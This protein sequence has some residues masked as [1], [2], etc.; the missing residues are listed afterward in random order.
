MDSSSS[1]KDGGVEKSTSGAVQQGCSSGS[2]DCFAEE[3][4]LSENPENH[5]KASGESSGGG[6]LW[7]PYSAEGRLEEMPSFLSECKSSGLEYE[8]EGR[9]ERRGW[10]GEGEGAHLGVAWSC[11]VLLPDASLGVPPVMHSLVE[12]QEEGCESQQDV[13]SGQPKRQQGKERGT[14]E[15]AGGRAVTFARMEPLHEGEAMEGC[16]GE[17][18]GSSLWGVLIEKQRRGVSEQDPPPYG[19]SLTNTYHI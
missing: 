2:S 8:E 19:L 6:V 15:L 5:C 16:E 10:G 7:N 11:P 1:G 4:L 13:H 18:V 12:R 3:A 17:S 9:K 14:H